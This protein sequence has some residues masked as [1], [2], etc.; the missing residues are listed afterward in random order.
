MCLD[1]TR[2]EL[3]GD[4]VHGHG[5]R[6]EDQTTGL[7]GL[8]VDTGERL[9][10]LVGEDGGLDVVGHCCGLMSLRL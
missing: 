3:H 4:R 10:G 9:G 5:A 2:D 6:D 7:D 8:A 1:I